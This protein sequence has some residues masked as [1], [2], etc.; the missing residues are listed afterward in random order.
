MPYSLMTAKE[1]T[2]PV[3]SPKI[4]VLIEEIIKNG[5]V[6]DVTSQ[7]SFA[8]KQNS[9]PAIQRATEVIAKVFPSELP[10]SP[11]EVVASV[12]QEE[13]LFEVGESPPRTKG[14]IIGFSDGE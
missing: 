14:D 8:V 1:S 10:T 2:I 13:P 3:K 12:F 5:Q 6:M 7:P 4:R 9:S 11:S